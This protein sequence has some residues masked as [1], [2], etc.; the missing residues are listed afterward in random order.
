M[1][2][3]IAILL[4]ALLLFGLLPAVGV[5]EDA[6]WWEQDLWSTEV[7]TELGALLPTYNAAENR[8]EI[9]SPEQL[10]YLSGVWKPEDTN[11]DGAPDAPCNG[12]YVLTQDLD[13][14]PLLEAIGAVLT[15]KTGA[16]TKGYMPPIAGLTDG[17]EAEGVHCAFFGTFDGQGHAIKTSLF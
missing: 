17:D 11:G 2:R 3:S 14:V 5:A 15:E 13:M 12:T 1:K 8:Y 10:L 16:E 4:A 9:D 7:L 6:P